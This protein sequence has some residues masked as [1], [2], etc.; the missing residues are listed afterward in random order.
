MSQHEVQ[1]TITPTSQSYTATPLVATPTERL[2]SLDAVRA[3]A[4]LLGV[5]LH[6][7]MS[8][9][10]GPQAWSAGSRSRAAPAVSE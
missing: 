10:P 1:Q 7:T 4:L 3:I 6:T 8:F 5:L 2:H 9:L